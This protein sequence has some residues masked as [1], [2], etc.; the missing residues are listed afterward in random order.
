MAIAT[1]PSTGLG[2]LLKI[3]T[4][5]DATIVSG[6]VTGGTFVTIS[7]QVST[8][9]LEPKAS[10]LETT[11][12]Q[13]LAGRE[14]I[15]NLDEPIDTPLEFNY[16]PGDAGQE[17]LI[18]AFNTN[19]HPTKQ[20]QFIAPIR[21]GQTTAEIRLFHG[22]PTGGITEEALNVS[23]LKGSLRVTG[24]YQRIAAT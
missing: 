1:T 9:S 10:Y 13:S 19:P 23:K 15:G 22:I 24:G 4:G 12:F 18:T 21:P 16:L 5:A 20:F 2:G 3:N 6:V 8:F 7:Q 17:A 11:N 14:Y